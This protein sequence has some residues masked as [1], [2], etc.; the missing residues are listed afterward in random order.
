MG[1]GI[2]WL[3]FIAGFI[4]V[5]GFFAAVFRKRRKRMWLGGFVVAFV[6]AVIAAP[7]VPESKSSV[8]QAYPPAVNQVTDTHVDAPAPKIVAAAESK[9]GFLATVDESITGKRI[10]G[11]P[12]KFLG[13]RVDLHGKVHNVL[14]E[15]SFNFDIGAISVSDSGD[16]SDTSA[17]ILVTCDS[18]G[19]LEADQKLRVIGTVVESTEGTNLMGGQ[20]TFPTV[21]A[22]FME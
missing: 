7:S 13:K 6:V 12:R 15:H 9:H 10:A 16:V 14:D 4:C 17:M 11:N 3:A 20:T 18:T 2:F 22:S 1:T 21:K 19:S 5:L 8:A